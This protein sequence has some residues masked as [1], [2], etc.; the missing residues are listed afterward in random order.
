MISDAKLNKMILS[1]KHN[2]VI[3]EKGRRRDVYIVGGYMRDLLRGRHCQDRDYIVF[4]DVMALA[5]K[6]KNYTGG[7]IIIFKRGT[8]TRI[9]TKG[10]PI[11]DLSHPQG[12]LREDLSKRDFTINA[13]AW[14]P[15]EGIIDPFQGIPDINKKCVR[16]ICDK[17]MR[18]DPLRMLRAYRFAAELNGVVE[19]S[20]RKLIKTLYNNIKETASERITLE[21]FQLLN[22]K[23]SSKYLKMSL[24]D[25]LLNNIFINS[26]KQ[27]E[28]NIKE[29]SLFE[30]L[31]FNKLPP[32]IKVKLKE[33]IS[34]N[35][36]YKGFLCLTLLMK[37][38]YT[39]D[40]DAC[41]LKLSRTIQK[42]MDLIHPR[43]DR[44]LVIGKNFD[45]YTET[46]DALIDLLILKNRLDCHS[47]YKRYLKI[48]NKGI[49]KSDDI[50]GYAGNLTGKVIGTIIKETRKAEYEGRVR[51]RTTAIKFIK[52]LSNSS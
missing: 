32:T 19:R 39:D 4:G 41:R 49:I 52:K 27:L 24:D 26:Y 38:L 6:L 28:Q 43:Y 5:R 46:K 37:K 31:T 44:R 14:S 12:T 30:K 34:Q 1:D 50:V 36:T 48:W 17:N 13:I 18:D 21:L 47:D 29:I 51:N 45:I 22:L 15:Y 3:F 9:A 40:K 20:T 8:T 23:T 11:F 7:K 42:R 25:E 2:A 35:L 33:T 16:V 10:G